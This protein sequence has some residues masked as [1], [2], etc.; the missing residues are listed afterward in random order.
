MPFRYL[1]KYL[2][3][4]FLSN[5]KNLGIIQVA[6]AL[7]PFLILPYLT[8]TVGVD[9]VGLAMLGQTIMTYFSVSV[10]NPGCC[11]SS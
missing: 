10:R 4:T 9:L 5:L 6:N 11:P 3:A 1:E 2:P 8:R 7:H